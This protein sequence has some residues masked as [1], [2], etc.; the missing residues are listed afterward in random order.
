MLGAAIGR[1]LH[2]ELGRS[3]D[4]LASLVVAGPAAGP[5]R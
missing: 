5:R 2:R 1:F 3:L 4:T